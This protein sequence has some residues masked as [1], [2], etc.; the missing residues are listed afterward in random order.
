MFQNYRKYLLLIV[1]LLVVLRFSGDTLSPSK[2][3]QHEKS[4][5]FDH[6]DPVNNQRMGYYHY[7]EGNKALKEG[8]WDEAVSNYKMALHHNPN[9]LET[10][11]NLSTTYLKMKQ[12]DEAYH[13]LKSVEE[14]SPSSPLIQ[15]N[16]ACYFSLTSQADSGLEALQKAVE[17]G[18]KNIK[19]IE[20]DPD[21]E[22]LRK[23]PRF[24]EWF[25]KVA[26][27]EPGSPSP[28]HQ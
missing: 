6:N 16:L 12:Y 4:A 21:L 20:A 13:T 9:S 22:N 26:L 27:Q 3:Q 14:K 25:K 18:Y 23:D 19:E 1:V 8:K 2:T 5:H 15:Y 17:L 7:N 28:P 10:Y 11:I 24:A